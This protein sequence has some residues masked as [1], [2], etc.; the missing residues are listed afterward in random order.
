[1]VPPVAILLSF[2]IC[3]VE[4]RFEFFFE[5]SRE[6]PSTRNP[7]KL[8]EAVVSICISS[9]LMRVRGGCGKISA[10]PGKVHP[11]RQTHP[12]QH[13]PQTAVRAMV[14]NNSS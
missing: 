12:H 6:M 1:M 11:T 9:D 3:F 13:R 8:S 2:L 5:R 7:G 10:T 4:H 14:R